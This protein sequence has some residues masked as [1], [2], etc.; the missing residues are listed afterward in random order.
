MITVSEKNNVDY[1]NEFYRKVSL[2]EESTFCS[3]IKQKLKEDVLIID[4]GCGSGR[5]TRSFAKEG[6]QV[7]GVDRSTSAILM[8]NENVKH[9]NNINFLNI[10]IADESN[11]QKLMDEVLN[12]NKDKKILVYSRFLLHSINKETETILLQILSKKLKSED[13]I[14]LEFRT[15]EDEEIEKVYS[16]H[17]RRYIDSEELIGNLENIYGFSTEYYYKGRGLSFYKN[18]DPYL[19]RMIIKKK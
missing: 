4:I 3:F 11:L 12:N 15:I 19:A 6:Y 1:W 8:N 14:A 9:I 13:L 7:Y 17:Y 18:E 5:D 2:D 16:N 10:D